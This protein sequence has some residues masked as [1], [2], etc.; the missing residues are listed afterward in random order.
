MQSSFQAYDFVCACLVCRCL[1]FTRYYLWDLGYSSS[2][3]PQPWKRD[4]A[5]AV[6]KAREMEQQAG[7]TFRDSLSS[8]SQAALNRAC[9]QQAIFLQWHVGWKMRV[10]F[11]RMASERSNPKPFRFIVHMHS[12]QLPMWIRRSSQACQKLKASSAWLPQ[13]GPGAAR[14]Q[15][16]CIRMGAVLLYQRCGR[17]PEVMRLASKKMSSQLG[18]KKLWLDVSRWDEMQIW[19][20]DASL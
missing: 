20:G 13:G 5:A 15:P 11:K 4:L 17:M 1:I 16:C 10:I 6:A 3:A 19:W 7:E 8:P 12:W 9:A 2:I 18:W 14:P